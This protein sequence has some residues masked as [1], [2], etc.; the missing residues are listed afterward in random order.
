MKNLKNFVIFLFVVL[1]E[2]IDYQEYPVKQQKLLQRHVDHLELVLLVWHIILLNL[3]YNY[4][5]QE[6]WDAVH[7][8]SESFPVLSSEVIKST[9]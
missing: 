7:G 2:L 9:C 8:L 6:A 4:D 3:G 1:D 5:S